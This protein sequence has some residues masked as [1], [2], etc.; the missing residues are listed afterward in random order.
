MENSFSAILGSQRLKISDVAK[1]TGIS[2][3]TLTSI[4]YQ[5]NENVSTKTLIK[6]CDFLQIS[7][8]E[9]I[10]YEPKKEGD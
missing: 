6:I 3:S 4:Y 1:A 5:Q 9:L 10:D 2:R 7:L 8:S